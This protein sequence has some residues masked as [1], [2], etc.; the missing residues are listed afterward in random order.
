M[1]DLLFLCHRIPYP[2]DKGDKI[3]AWHLL[4]ALA[5]RW[6]VHLGC[7]VDDPADWAHVAHLRT[8]C[9]DVGAFAL[10]PHGARLRALVGLR[11]GRPLTLGYYADRRLRAW[12][13][14]RLDGGRIGHAVAFSSA[15]AA[16]LPDRPGLRRVLD[17]VDVDSEKW[18]AYAAAARGPMR[19]VWAREAR[20]LLAHERDAARRFDHTL[21]VAAHEA[22][23]FVA[24]A[25]EAAERVSVVENGVDFDFFS[26]RHPMADPYG[27]EGPVVVF[28]GTMDYRPNVDAVGWF[29]HEALPLL[30]ADFPSLRFAIVGAG[31]GQD[32][33][34]LA[35]LPGVLVT[36][37]VPDIRP[38]VTHADLVVAPLRIARG[39]Q[40]K[41][42]EAMAM[43]RP[44]L[45]TPE[46][47]EGL[48]AVP[49]RD[50]LVA[51]GAA[52][53]ARRAA[54][55]LRG[56]HPGLGA[57]ARRL[58]ETGY[59]WAVT[60]AA[61]DRLPALAPPPETPGRR[62]VPQHAHAV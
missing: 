34:A 4:R 51:A 25:P 12:V 15:M 48:R 47:F 41:V 22:A 29:A 30:R 38:Y 35:A 40:N 9:A 53:T 13:D 24:L 61:L 33:R 42:L 50:L 2:P 37:R 57:A 11:P 1:R 26:P 5:D 21:M 6:R 3:R 27:G 45:A 32:V 20:T 31:P 28:T 10:D 8:V 55:V 18:A 7:F 58:I 54:E 36:G 56:E 23:R 62:R 44:V 16:Y 14:A 59:D 39:I 60:L 19:A 52:E 43:A 49:G 46:A 17:M